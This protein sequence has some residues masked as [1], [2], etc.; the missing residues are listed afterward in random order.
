MVLLC[1]HLN[2]FTKLLFRPLKEILVLRRPELPRKERRQIVSYDDYLNLRDT[3]IDV[4][5]SVF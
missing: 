5:F 3:S 4:L 2:K 1:S